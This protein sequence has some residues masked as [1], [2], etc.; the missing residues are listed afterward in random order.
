VLRCGEEVD[1][2]G[3]LRAV[4][5]A[6]AAPD[7]PGVRSEKAGAD[8]KQRALADPVLADRRMMISSP[9]LAARRS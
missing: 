7:R 4:P 5:D 8:A 6:A 1:Q 2:L 3:L 9:A